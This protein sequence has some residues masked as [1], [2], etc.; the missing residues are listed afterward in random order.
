MDRP[1]LAVMDARQLQHAYE[2]MEVELNEYIEQQTTDST[3]EYG[4]PSPLPEEKIDVFMRRITGD[5]RAAYRAMGIFCKDTWDNNPCIH[6]HQAFD[7]LNTLQKT[8]LMRAQDTFVQMTQLQQQ[9]QINQTRIEYLNNWFGKNIPIYIPLEREIIKQ[10]YI[11]EFRLRRHFACFI[12]RGDFFSRGS[13]GKTQLKIYNLLNENIFQ[14]VKHMPV[15]HIKWRSYEPN[16]SDDTGGTTYFSKS[17]SC[18]IARSKLAKVVRDIIY[19]SSFFRIFRLINTIHLRNVT[20]GQETVTF[21]Q[22]DRNK[23]KENFASKLARDHGIHSQVL[24]DAFELALDFIYMMFLDLE[25]GDELVRW[26]NLLA[27]IC[28]PHIYQNVVKEG[29]FQPYEVRQPSNF[30][31]PYSICAGAMW[32]AC[33]N[34]GVLGWNNKRRRKWAGN[35]RLKACYDPLDT[36]LDCMRVETQATVQP[37]KW[38]HDAS[39]HVDDNASDYWDSSDEEDGLT[40]DEENYDEAQEQ[41][42]TGFTAQLNARNTVRLNHFKSNAQR[43][44]NILNSSRRL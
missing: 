43:V 30:K 1:T 11:T 27:R 8:W 17:N 31:E 12:H 36:S 28:P 38:R 22:V 40:D 21:N 25:E 9:W 35:K 32:R 42:I 4:V 34:R 44:L 37:L 3:G 41:K 26:M 20:Q 7:Q 10:L 2:A 18:A 15:T 16:I 14:R 5:K 33:K 19:D 24:N 23:S 6:I 29:R 39:Q 13:D